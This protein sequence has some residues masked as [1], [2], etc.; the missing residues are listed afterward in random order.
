MFSH[1]VLCWDKAALS[2]DRAGGA[3]KQPCQTCRFVHQWLAWTF[4]G[5]SM[6]PML[7]SSVLQS[8]SKKA[9]RKRVHW[10]VCTVYLYSIFRVYL[11]AWR[12]MSHQN[13]FTH[14]C[15]GSFLQESFF[16]YFSAQ[17]EGSSADAIPMSAEERQKLSSCC[18]GRL[19]LQCFPRL[20]SRESESLCHLQGSVLA[21]PG[22]FVLWDS[23]V[24]PGPAGGLWAL[25][26]SPLESG[27]LVL[28]DLIQALLETGFWCTKILMN[29]DGLGGR[30]SGITPR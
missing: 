5:D 10:V 9:T 23:P 2:H 28:R 27:E 8:N 29:M 16:S 20:Y 17:V 24:V 19:Q 12:R 21:A 7:H 6:A 22:M 15:K 13:D 1:S 18:R 3:H 30:S 11:E 26:P 4:K 25:H 14:L